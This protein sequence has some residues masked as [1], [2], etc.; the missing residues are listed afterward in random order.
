MTISPFQ[1]PR[2]TPFGLVEKTV[3]SLTG[4]RKLDGYYRRRPEGIDT[5]NF[6]AYTL[7]VLGVDYTVSPEDISKIPATGSTVVVANHPL[8]GVE[9]VIL[10]K[11][12]RQVRPDVKV[13][14]NYYLKRIPELSDLFIGVDV[15][16][17]KEAKKANMRA[18][19]EAHQ[20]VSDGGLLLVFPAG[21]VSTFDKDGLLNDKAWSRSVAGIVRKHKATALPIFI[22]GRNSR[23]FYRAGTIH[24]LLRTVLLGREL[25]NKRG[26]PIPLSIGAPIAWKEGK[27]FE[28]DDALVNYLRLN[29]YLLNNEEVSESAKVPTNGIDIMEAASTESIE[30][31]LAALPENAKLL[32]SN[33]FDVFCCRSKHIPIVLQEIGRMREL[34]FRAVGEGTGLD[35]DIDGYDAYYLHLFIWDREA[36]QLVGAYRLGRVQEIVKN[37]GIDG[38]YS[39]SLFQYDE[40][41]VESMGNA[42]EMGR[43]VIDEKY[44]RSLTALL[45]LW[46]GIA[47][48]VYRN[49]HITTLYGPVSI[50]N[51]YPLKARRLL[52]ECLS[53]HHY[54]DDMAQLV[55]P[56]TPLETSSPVPWHTSMLSALGDV[57]LLSKVVGRMSSGLG[58]PVLLRQYLGLNG[59][60]VCFN[61]DPAFNNALD[62]LIVVDLRKVPAK[63]LG[64]YMGKEHAVE[65]LTSHNGQE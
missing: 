14:A 65:Y 27:S 13:L 39:R 56:T 3:E 52:A 57:Q 5:D 51:D 54:D 40:R 61:V 50:S 33:E 4:L 34:N 29:T 46:K 31:E 47:E 49:P 37:L 9:G 55:K 15:F 44:Q 17:G 62:G 41:F 21:E 22:G 20:H 6:L 30:Q 58:V 26:Q 35:C 12:L 53:I 59:K 32:S 19:R 38:L 7:D 24:P 10:A 23:K 2:K 63:T 43:S 60:L 48:Y 28:S 42:M 1:L 16:E 36:R 64:R 45:L 18:L 8:G 25:L 11:L